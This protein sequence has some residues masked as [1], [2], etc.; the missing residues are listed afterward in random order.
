MNKKKKEKLPKD[1]WIAMIF[2][3]AIIVVIAILLSGSPGHKSILNQDGP[4]D[5]ENTHNQ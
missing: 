2:A 5:T 3:A 4:A 1:V